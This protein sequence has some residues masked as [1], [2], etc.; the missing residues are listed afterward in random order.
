M[1][2]LKRSGPFSPLPLVV[3]LAIVGLHGSLWASSTG[4]DDGSLRDPIAGE[5]FHVPDPQFEFLA[6]ELLIN[7]PEIHA[8]R[9][10]TLA[11]G[12]RVAQARSLPDPKLGYRLFVSGP[13]TRVGP[14]EQAIEISQGLPWRG[15]RGLQGER[16][17]HEARSAEWNLE[18][19]QRS[20]IASLKRAYFQAAYLQEAL[21]VNAEDR[22]LLERFEQFALS[23]YST[24][25]GSQ[26]AVIK[27]QTDVTRL[28]NRRIELRE[29]LEVTERRIARLL[30]R[31]HSELV[32]EPIALRVP[33]PDLEPGE[34]EPRLFDEHPEIRAALEQIEAG[35]AWVQRKARDNYPDF[36]VGLGYTDVGDRED[37]AG[38]LMP[39]QGNGRDIWALSLKLNIPLYRKR[40]R[41][42]VAEAT[43]SVAS[44]EHS[45]KRTRDRLEFDLREARLQIESLDER[46]LLYRDVLIPQAEESLASAESS[47]K[48]GRL[49]VL[50]LLDA[51]RVLFQIRLAQHRQIADYWIALAA[52][53]ETMAR[54]IPV[55]SDEGDMP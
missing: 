51:E 5:D 49:G 30:G 29:Q 2:H 28:V 34:E 14:Q 54:P 21:A 47:Y 32:L 4:L 44:S 45:L 39:P 8:I 10:A 35:R 38:R 31:P 23:R 16:F 43:H 40:V 55:S 22:D 13:E 7:N 6:N 27:I 42:G 1:Y 19:V 18:A 15:K 17:E 37:Q 11:R 50:D 9:S 25:D 24:G 48:T 20:L 33:Q 3:C 52:L 41:A 36:V 46:V 26:Q 12:E 53:E